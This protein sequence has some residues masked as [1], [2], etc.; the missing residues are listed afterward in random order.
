MMISRARPYAGRLAENDLKP[1]RKTCGAFPR[2]TP[3][4]S[5][6]WRTCLICTPRSPIPESLSSNPSQSVAGNCR[7]NTNVYRP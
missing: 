1:R 7:I 3:N 2:W 4:T 6:A 5:P